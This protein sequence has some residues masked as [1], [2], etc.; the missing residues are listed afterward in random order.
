MQSALN[1]V[2]SRHPVYLHTWMAVVLY[3]PTFDGYY[4]EVLQ[5]QLDDLNTDYAMLQ[6]QSEELRVRNMQGQMQLNAA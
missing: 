4:E 1:N 6:M 5:R 3:V 2:N